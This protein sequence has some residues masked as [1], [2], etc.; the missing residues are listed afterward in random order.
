MV[1]V[2][3]GHALLGGNCRQFPE[4]VQVELPDETREVLRF[5]NAEFFIVEDLILEGR[6]VDCNAS[7]SVTPADGLEPSA[8]H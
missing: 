2:L 1:D 7:S 3:P 4:S 6:A 5:E 8:I